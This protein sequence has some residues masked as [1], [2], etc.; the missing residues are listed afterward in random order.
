MNKVMLCG[1][2]PRSLV[3]QAGDPGRCLCW[4]LCGEAGGGASVCRRRTTEPGVRIP[5]VHKPSCSRPASLAVTWR[6]SELHFPHPMCY[7]GPR[8]LR[9]ISRVILTSNPQGDLLVNTGIVPI[10]QKRKWAPGHLARVAVVSAARQIRPALCL[11]S[12]GGTARP[13]MSAVDV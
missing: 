5:S 7:P 12:Q 9:K 2:P 8:M 4:P 3:I 13:L 1:W 10:L 6:A 11:L